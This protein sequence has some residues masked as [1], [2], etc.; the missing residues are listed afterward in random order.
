[1]IDKVNRLTL[2]L[3]L[4]NAVMHL[5]PS[6]YTLRMISTTNL[7][8]EPGQVAAAGHFWTML[9][10]H[11]R[12]KGSTLTTSYDPRSPLADVFPRKALFGPSFQVAYAIHGPVLMSPERL[13]AAGSRR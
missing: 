1:M 7:W 2:A 5:L 13:I 8:F 6:D 9:R 12:D 11:M 10:W 4:M 3:R